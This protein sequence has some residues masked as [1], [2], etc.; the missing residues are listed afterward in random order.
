[1]HEISNELVFVIVKVKI[2]P[3]WGRVHTH[4][5]ANGLSDDHISDNEIGSGDEMFNKSFQLKST[6]AVDTRVPFWFSRPENLII[7]IP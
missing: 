3:K 2:V 7:S 4:R 1:M 6:N 5:N